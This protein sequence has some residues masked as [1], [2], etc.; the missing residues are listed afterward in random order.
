VLSSRKLKLI[1]TLIVLVL[2]FTLTA[3][4]QDEDCAYGYKIYVRDEAGKPV[5]NAKLEVSGVTAKDKLPDEVKPFLGNDGA[6]IVAG[7]T[8]TTV[9]GNFLLR[10]SAKGFETYERKFSFPECE[11]Q[12]IELRLHAEG[13]TNKA[14]FERLSNLHGMVYDEEMKPFKGAKV[15]ISYAGGQVLHASSNAYGFYEIDLPQGAATTIRVTGDGIADVVFENYKLDEDR[16]TLN[17]PV[18][19]KCKQKESKN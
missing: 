15:E 16:P 1:F 14:T 10:V 7:E 17:I 12:T 6:Y 5:E 8:G 4:A 3:E 11:Y 13:S 9:E 19:R 18:C 2:G